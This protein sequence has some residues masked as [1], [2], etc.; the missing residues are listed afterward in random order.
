MAPSDATQRSY[1]E[2]R[3]AALLDLQAAARSQAATARRQA[4]DLAP[5]RA[6]RKELARLCRLA[7]AAQ[8]RHDQLARAVRAV[9]TE[10][11]ADEPW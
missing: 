7:E 9:E 11:Q 3:R 1:L 2:G 8:A 5:T 4:A 6:C 10:I